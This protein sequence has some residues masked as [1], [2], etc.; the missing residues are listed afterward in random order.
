[1]KRKTFI[2]TI[3][4]GAAAPLFF[5]FLGYLLPQTNRRY[6]RP[7]G[8][9]KENEFINACIGCGSCA[10]VCPNKCIELYGLEGGI[11]NIATPKINARA[12]GCILCMACTNA[13]PTGAL[14]KI[15][16]TKKGKASVRMGKAYIATDICYSYAGRTCGVCYRACPLPGLALSVDL[17]EVPKVNLKHCVGCG[18]CENACIHMPQAIRII[19]D[20]ELEMRN[21]G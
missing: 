15:E 4:G 9:K 18:L 16:S 19:P 13:C 14:K 10:S 1:M 17:Y 20:A 12:K 2:H 21:A 8:A 3:L 6:L 7:P 5:P 11:S